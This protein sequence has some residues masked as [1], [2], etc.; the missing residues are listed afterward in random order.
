ML[1]F[2]STKDAT[3]VE[4]FVCIPMDHL[5]RCPMTE[6]QS[7]LL[8]AILTNLV[9]FNEQEVLARLGDDITGEFMFRLHESMEKRFQVRLDIFVKMM[10]SFSIANNPGQLVMYYAYLQYKAYKLDKTLI[11]LNDFTRLI[12]ANGFLNEE[13]LR[14]IWENQKVRVPE[15]SFGSDNLLDYGSAY[16][17]ILLE[18][19]LQ[20]KIN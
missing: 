9:G 19:A 16:E 10:L 18:D 14:V 13:D 1:P 4:E 17:S 15:G 6:D 2:E 20:Q 5:R 12:F 11:D 8:F 7:D 3:A